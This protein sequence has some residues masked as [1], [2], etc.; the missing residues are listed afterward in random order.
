MINLFSSGLKGPENRKM[1]LQAF[2]IN[3][4]YLNNDFNLF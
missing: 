2:I 1:I 4:T 3:S